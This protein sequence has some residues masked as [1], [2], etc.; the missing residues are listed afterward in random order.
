MHQKYKAELLCDEKLGGSMLWDFNNSNFS[1]LS[2]L[3]GYS[4]AAQVGKTYI[5]SGCL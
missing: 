5:Q 4:E 2:F 3:T 1:V